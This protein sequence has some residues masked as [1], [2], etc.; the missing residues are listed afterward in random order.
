MS[1]FPTSLSFVLAF[2]DIVSAHFRSVRSEQE[3]VGQVVIAESGRGDQGVLMDPDFSCL[4]LR[5]F[6]P[7]SGSQSY[8]GS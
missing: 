1:S 2:E 7:W 5:L 6:F 8:L 4:E 3:A